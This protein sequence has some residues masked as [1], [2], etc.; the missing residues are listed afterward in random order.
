MRI[1][2]ASK[3]MG[4]PEQLISEIIEEHNIEVDKYGN[5]DLTFE[6]MVQISRIYQGM[7][8]RPLIDWRQK[9]Q[10]L[11]TK[12]YKLE[13]RLGDRKTKKWYPKKINEVTV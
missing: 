8:K 5:H 11:Q 10:Q 1:E 12:V 7:R 6:A 3:L 4:V 13:L 9:A 2:E